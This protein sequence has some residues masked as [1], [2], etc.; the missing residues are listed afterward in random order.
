MRQWTRGLAALV[1][2]LAVVLTGCAVV[3]APKAGGAAPAPRAPADASSACPAAPETRLAPAADRCRGTAG[4]PARPGTRNVLG[5]ALQP[6][7]S[8]HATGF[9]RDGYCTT[10]TD[11]RGVHVVC[12]RVTEAFLTFSRARGNDLVTARG[13]FPGLKDGDGW[14]LC[15]SRWREAYEA[16]VAPPVVLEATH[17]AALMTSPLDDLDHA[18]R[19]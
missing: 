18:R 16:G 15:A 6:C 19:R 5:G 2:V 8:L 12:A 14:C 7:P 17:E 13:T 1:V 10:G 11:D 4:G 9:Y 3:D